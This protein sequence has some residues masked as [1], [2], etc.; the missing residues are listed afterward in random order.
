M[1]GLLNAPVVRTENKIDMKPNRVKQKFSTNGRP[2]R[3]AGDRSK[4]CPIVVIRSECARW[5]K[6]FRRRTAAPLSE[7]FYNARHEAF[8]KAILLE[9]LCRFLKSF[10]TPRRARIAPRKTEQSRHI[11][12]RRAGYRAPGP[13]RLNKSNPPV[14]MWRYKEPHNAVL[15]EVNLT[16]AGIPAGERVGGSAQGD[17]CVRVHLSNRQNAP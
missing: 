3:K 14:S 2:Q 16:N 11:E 17:A 6:I 5:S 8:N 10:K 1:G 15:T 7:P 13:V 12:L 4:L 9:C